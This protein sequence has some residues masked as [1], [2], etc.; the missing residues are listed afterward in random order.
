MV[1]NKNTD[2][3]NEIMECKS[4]WKGNTL[5]T[6]PWGKVGITSYEDYI[7]YYPDIKEEEIDDK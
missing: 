6:T 3:T 5:P 1:N 4:T 2:I 7:K